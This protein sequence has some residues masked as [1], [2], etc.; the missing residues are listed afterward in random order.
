MNDVVNTTVTSNEASAPSIAPSNPIDNIAPTVETCSPSPQ[1]VQSVEPVVKA[2]EV[3][4]TQDPIVKTEEQEVK[5]QDNVPNE[6]QI[7]QTTEIVPP[8][9]PEV[10][11]TE[12][13]IKFEP[14]KFPEESK[15]DPKSFDFVTKRL[16][17]FVGKT[18]ADQLEVQKLGQDYIDSVLAITQEVQKNIIESQK[19]AEAARRE[20]DKQDF[21]NDPF[22]GGNRKDT[23]INAANEWIKTHGGDAKQQQEFADLMKEHGLD[24]HPVVLRTLSYANK[25]MAE[26]KMLAASDFPKSSGGKYDKWYGKST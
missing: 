13:E 18:K 17:D 19:Q 2:D 15:V 20:K 9:E 14:F 6:T 25:N 16:S 1:Q 22:I 3:V 12:A 10:Q 26:G 4:V 7:D 5:I 11:V 23:T 8:V 24:F 21:L